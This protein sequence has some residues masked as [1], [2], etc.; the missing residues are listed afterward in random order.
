MA[1]YDALLVGAG[2]FNAVI[3]AELTKRGKSVLVVD[4]RTSVGGNCASTS[5]D[6]IEVHQYGAHIFHTSDPAV[7][8]FAN[9]YDMFMPFVN[10]PIAEYRRAKTDSARIFNLPFNMNTFSQ[11][12]PGR[13]EYPAGAKSIIEEKTREFRKDR[14]ANLEEKALSMVGEEMYELFIRHYTEKQWGCKCTELD[15]G[16]ITR[17]PL[18]FTY[19]NNYFNDTWQGIPSHGYSRWIAEMMSGATIL[20]GVDYID[21]RKRLDELADHVFYSGMLDELFG[22][23]EGRLPY[24]SLRFVTEKFDS[25]NFQGVA[26]VNHTGPYPEYTRT[27]EHKHFTPWKPIDETGYTYITLE[28]PK[29]FTKGG[30]A[31]YPVRNEDSV[32]MWK[33]YM[34]MCPRNMTVT[35]RLGRFEYND[36]DDTIAKALLVAG[37]VQ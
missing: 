1:K 22:Y 17:I 16:I 19:D 5:K 32:A 9:R 23:S 12:W 7:W 30:E 8:E 10:S 2:L 15:P 6:G 29:E 34:D 3:A 24:R 25:A 13:C 21:E 28:Y 33:T 31:Y 37:S 26:V 11:L 27:I 18:R 4:R 20:L 35:G 14:Y 36:M